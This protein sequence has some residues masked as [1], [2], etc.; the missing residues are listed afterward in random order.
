MNLR[1]LELFIAV[2]ETGSFTAAAER[3]GV[4]QSFVSA[5]V[6]RLENELGGVLLQR[7]KRP[8]VPTVA[9]VALLRHAGAALAAVKAAREEVRSLSAGTTGTVVIGAPPMVSAFLLAGPIASFVLDH[10]DIRLKV[11]QM[12]AERVRGAVMR[13]EIDVGIIA[14]WR[15]WE[16]VSTTLLRWEPIVAWVKAESALAGQS[17][18]HWEA[19]LDQPLVAF[20]EGYYQRTRLEQEARRLGMHLNIAV[21]AEAISMIGSFVQAGVGVATMLG[22]VPPPPGIKAVNLLADAKV[23]I[24]LCEP[25]K[26]SGS[27][28]GRLLIRHLKSR[29]TEK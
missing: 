24:A 19:V 7:D 29:L 5:A 18:L 13:G 8:L 9:G 21:E 27:A 22:A 17:T 11:I 6:R 14:G 15:S 1:Q 2:A 20:P 28:T 3:Q 12:G 23:P 25:G 10:P 26:L 16:G 4:A